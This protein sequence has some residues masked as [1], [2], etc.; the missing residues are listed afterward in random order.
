[1]NC[2]LPNNWACSNGD[3][4]CSRCSGAPELGGGGLKDCTPVKV[5]MSVVIQDGAL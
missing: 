2:G 5:K 1:M 4:K 3:I